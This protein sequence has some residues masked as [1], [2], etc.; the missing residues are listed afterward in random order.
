ME[1]VHIITS[2]CQQSN[3][4]FK[5]TAQNLEPTV[6]LP[7]LLLGQQVVSQLFIHKVVVLHALLGPC[8]R[9]LHLRPQRIHVERVCARETEVGVEV[10]RQ[11]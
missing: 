5:I 6:L 10:N 9:P 11:R 8:L 1:N 7:F 3:N 4:V 2:C